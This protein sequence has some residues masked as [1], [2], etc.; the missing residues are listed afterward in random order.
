MNDYTASGKL[1]A[2]LRVDK[3]FVQQTV[4][5]PRMAAQELCDSVRALLRDRFVADR[6]FERGIDRVVDKGVQLSGRDVLR[7]R[8][9][10]QRFTGLQL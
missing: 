8:N 4:L 6:L 2:R 3:F 1:F 5:I 9:L 7:L 10:R